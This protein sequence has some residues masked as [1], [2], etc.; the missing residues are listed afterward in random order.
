MNYTFPLKVRI[1]DPNRLKDGKYGNLV[2]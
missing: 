1:Y 2:A